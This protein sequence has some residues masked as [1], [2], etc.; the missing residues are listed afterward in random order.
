MTDYLFLGKNTANCD[1]PSRKGCE[2]E[3]AVKVAHDFAG[4]VPQYLGQEHTNP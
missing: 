1:W 2:I 4:L 3:G